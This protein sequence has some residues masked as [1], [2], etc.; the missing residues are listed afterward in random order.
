MM[1]A[2]GVLGGASLFLMGQASALWQVVV[3]TALLWFSGG[4]GLSA[5]SVLAGLHTQA[6]ERGKAFGM[7]ALASPLG[8]LIGGLLIGHLVE[9]G[10][11]GLMFSVVTLVWSM[12][13]VLSLSRVKDGAAPAHASEAPRNTAPV[14]GL[15]TRYVLLVITVLL[16]AMTVSVG[17]MGLSLAMKT[18]GFS[19]SALGTANAA[20]G[21]IT[22]PLTLMIGVLS[23]RLGR[24]SFLLLGY[25]AAAAGTWMLAGAQNLWQFYL[26]ASLVLVS[27]SVI[28]SMAPAFASDLMSRRTMEKALPFLNSMNWVSGVIGFAASGWAL[29]AL[30][31]AILY[32]GAA[33]LSLAATL[34]VALLPAAVKTTVIP[35]RRPA[36]EARAMGD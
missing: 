7:L 19:A 29:D 17:R 24:K 25:L 23:D 16:G 36:E 2:A 18:A 34:V 33:V 32:G 35:V 14:E 31:P 21:L 28:A 10:G 27:R 15:G 4:V 26:V 11:Y 8:A 9:W 30:G 6:A 5:S 13:P 20:A 12:L 3:L 22:I 1:T